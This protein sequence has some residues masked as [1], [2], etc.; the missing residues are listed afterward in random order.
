MSNTPQHTSTAQAR[1]TMT[2]PRQP[3]QPTRTKT[4]P[5]LHARCT[6]CGDCLLWQG[7]HNG[8]GQPRHA[9]GSVRRAVWALARGPVPANRLVTVTCGQI[10]CLNPAHLALTT[11][12]AVTRIVHN[13]PDV[14][15]RRSAA[16]ARTNQATMG[17]INMAI[18]RQIRASTQTGVDLARHYGVST[19]LVSLVRQGKTWVERTASP[20]RG[21]GA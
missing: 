18:A 16:C 20:W 4:L 10:A 17:K 9:G 11:R 7:A 3:A 1:P 2:Q 21:L 14:R 12:G 6:E 13:R 19:S 5:E 15:M 8:T